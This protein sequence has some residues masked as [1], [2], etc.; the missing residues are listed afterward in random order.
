MPSM[1]DGVAEGVL[2]PERAAQV[3]L[4]IALPGEAEAAVKLDSPITGKGVRITRLR[5]GHAQ[6]HLDLRRGGSRLDQRGRM[7]DVGPAPL[8]ADEYVYGGV[9]QALIAADLAAKAVR[10]LR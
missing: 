6:R 9:L 8:Q 10:V 2:R 4:G 1:M 3:E 5:L 7:V